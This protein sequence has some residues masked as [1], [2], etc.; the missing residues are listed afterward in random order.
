M[1]ISEAQ[2]KRSPSFVGC[3]GSKAGVPLIH[4]L[5]APGERLHDNLVFLWNICGGFVTLASMLYC[6]FIIICHYFM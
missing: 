5:L 6:N 4:L 2:K 3:K 1:K